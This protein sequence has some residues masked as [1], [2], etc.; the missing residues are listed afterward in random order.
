MGELPILFYTVCSLT[1]TDGTL[2]C[3]IEF[4]DAVSVDMAFHLSGVE[5]GD[6]KLLITRYVYD[7]EET[8]MAGK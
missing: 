1:R 5:L 4:E 2:E 7:L 3:V 8:P 6:R